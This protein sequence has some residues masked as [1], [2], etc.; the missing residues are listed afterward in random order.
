M[1]DEI[2]QLVAEQDH[3]SDEPCVWTS[4]SHP[5][6]RFPLPTSVLQS[7]SIKDRKQTGFR[8]TVETCLSRIQK[9]MFHHQWQTAAE[10]MTNYFQILE[11]N[12]TRKQESASKVIWRMGTAILQH[13]PNSCIEDANSF[14]GK[15]KSIGVK[16]YLKVCL[17]H[18]IHL[19]CNGKMDEA[20]RELS[21]AETW[22]YGEKSATQHKVLK[23]I[24]GYRALLD[25]YTWVKK[26]SALQEKAD[27]AVDSG[28]AQEMH[29][30]FRQASI[31]LHDVVEHP[32]VWDPF[33]L[34][35]VNLLDFY[36][37]FEEA[38]KVLNDYAY[39]SKFPPNPNAH[40]YLYEFLKKHHTSPKKLLKVLRILY[41]LVPSHELMLEFNSLLLQSEKMKHHKE[42]LGVLFCL[43]DFP[44]WKENYRTWKCLIKQMKKAIAEGHSDWIKEQW[45]LRQD[46]WPAFHFSKFRAHRDFEEN[47]SYACR[48]A[49]IA[50]ILTGKGCKYFITIYRLG[51]KVQNAKMKKMK[52]Y[53][54]DHSL[55]Q[56]SEC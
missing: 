52:Q 19:M 50:G 20:Y 38:L 3:S 45:E 26:N 54:K 42:A 40:V 4:C 49:V 35:Y 13:H 1:D 12:T 34:S 56:L 5:E 32:G 8:R 16:H 36:D 24:Q 21:L 17:E 46:W 44:T 48:K 55:L 14:A 11:D 53:V 47:E 10:L 43:L 39:N 2:A 15:M 51:Y 30:Y 29:N 33:I 25:Y 18:A 6:I 9:A 23:L 27:D 31:G 37:G 22:R 41:Q 28:T 7:Q